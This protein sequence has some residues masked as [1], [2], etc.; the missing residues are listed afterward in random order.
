MSVDCKGQVNSFENSAGR[1]KRLMRFFKNEDCKWMGEKLRCSAQLLFF[2]MILAITLLIPGRNVQAASAKTKALRAYKAFLEQETIQWGKDEYYTAVPTKDCS[3]ALAYIDKN[4]VPELILKNA[5]GITHV[6]GYGTVYT[7]K[8]GKVQ[9][10]DN[11]QLDGAFYY[12]KKTGIYVSNNF[13]G[14]YITLTYNKMSGLKSTAKISESKNAFT[15][16]KNY[17]KLSSTS[18]KRISKSKFNSTLKKLVGSKKR[19]TAKFYRNTKKN[20]AKYLK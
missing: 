4:A 13:S 12:Y 17:S 16:E 3:F 19:T 9:P 11:I 18:Y 6:A 14:G 5:K 7:Y 10:V 1:R 2:V 8:N 20:R 15:K